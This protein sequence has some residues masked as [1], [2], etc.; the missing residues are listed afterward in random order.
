MDL[1]VADESSDLS[2]VE[3]EAAPTATRR[4]TRTR[5][6]AKGKQRESNDQRE[7]IEG[8]LGKSRHSLEWGKLYARLTRA[9]GGNFDSEREHGPA[10]ETTRRRCS[11]SESTD[12]LQDGPH[13]SRYYP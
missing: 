10:E 8:I 1:D 3:S 12:W 7:T 9:C 13:W 2:S 6:A 5:A 4:S 11:N